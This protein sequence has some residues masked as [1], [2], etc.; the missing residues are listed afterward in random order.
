VQVST[1]PLIVVRLGRVVQRLMC[2]GFARPS[3]LFCIYVMGCHCSSPPMLGKISSWPDIMDPPALQLLHVPERHGA[4][5]ATLR[6]PLGGPIVG[7][8]VVEH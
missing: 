8:W 5:R 1:F 6:P 7:L 3:L 4:A 2:E